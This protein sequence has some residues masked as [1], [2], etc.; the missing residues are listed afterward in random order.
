MCR[1]F[2]YSGCQG[3]ANN[4]V[5]LNDCVQACVRI[6]SQ[7]VALPAEVDLFKA[8]TILISGPRFLSK[9]YMNPDKIDPR[10]PTIYGKAKILLPT[11]QKKNP[12]SSIRNI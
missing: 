4:F 10:G 6:P 8:R 2:I 9:F 11:F 1:P 7:P 5:N 3:N 12:K